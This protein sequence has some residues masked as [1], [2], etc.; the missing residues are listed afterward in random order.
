M[1]PEVTT[2]DYEDILQLP[3]PQ[4]LWRLPSLATSFSGDH[5]GSLQLFQV[6]ALPLSS[7]LGSAFALDLI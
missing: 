7:I 2:V 4:R 3:L 1:Y 5:N 6:C